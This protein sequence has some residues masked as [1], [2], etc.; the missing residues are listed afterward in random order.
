MEEQG[1][2]DNLRRDDAILIKIRGAMSPTCVSAFYPFNYAETQPDSASLPDDGDMLL[3]SPS[4]FLSSSFIEKPRTHTSELPVS[5]NFSPSRLGK[6]RK[7]KAESESV[8]ISLG[9]LLFPSSVGFVL[10]FQ[11]VV[12][13]FPIF[14]FPVSSMAFAPKLYNFALSSEFR[15]SVLCWKLNKFKVAAP[16]FP[17][18]LDHTLAVIW[19][20]FKDEG[21]EI[22]CLNRADITWAL[23][24]LESIDT[25]AMGSATDLELL[26]E[27]L[28]K[29]LIARYASEDEKDVLNQTTKLYDSIDEPVHSSA[30]EDFLSLPEVID[31]SFNLPKTV[32]IASPPQKCNDD[33]LLLRLRAL[34]PL[35]KNIDDIKTMT[36]P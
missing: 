33:E 28:R 11:S 6:H 30:L 35:I 29:V 14:K 13:P 15:D 1:D 26:I 10:A 12:A 9:K 18:L 31:E 8:F 34:N 17:V 27:F 24:F 21:A 16:S 20:L 23:R 25:S 36:T 32:K 5:F 2:D 19:L 3:S 7:I 22:S 4:P